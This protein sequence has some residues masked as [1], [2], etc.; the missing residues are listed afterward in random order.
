MMNVMG[1]NMMDYGGGNMMGYN[2]LGYGFG[3]LGFLIMLLF[4]IGV[5]WLII[6]IIRQL[7][8]D[9]TESNE[10][11]SEILKKRFARGEISKKEYLERKK[12]LK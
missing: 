2:N 3:W 4:W 7:T 9:K 12:E 10:S 6:W 5:V 1:N 11:A 8:K